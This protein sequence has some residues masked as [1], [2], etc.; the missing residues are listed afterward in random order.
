M[1]DWGEGVELLKAR[2]L[3]RMGDFE[4]FAF[5]GKHAR[6]RALVASLICTKD[7]VSNSRASAYSSTLHRDNV[8]NALLI[9][10]NPHGRSASPDPKRSIEVGALLATTSLLPTTHQLESFH[11]SKTR[12]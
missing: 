4:E 1:S 5:C 11:Y 12:R 3:K 9:L 8:K 10:P 7:K 2:V 6:G